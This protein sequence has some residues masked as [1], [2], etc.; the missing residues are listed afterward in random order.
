[1]SFHPQKVEQFKSVY[2]ANWNRIR[3]FKGCVH[4]E[5]LQGKNEPNVFFTFS[6]WESEEH[7][8]Q[9]RNSELFAGVWSS[10]KVLFNDKPQAWTV[11]ELEL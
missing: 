8:E 2:A 10:T 4:V 3:G 11:N 9:Y 1:M 5:L 7:L 6:I